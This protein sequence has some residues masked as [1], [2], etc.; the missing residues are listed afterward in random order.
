[1]DYRRV[2]KRI[3]LVWITAGLLFFVMFTSWSVIAYRPSS[4][5]RAATRADALVRVEHHD[6]I[7]TF[8][9]VTNMQARAAFAFVPGALVDARAYAP[10]VRAA[11]AAGYRGYIIELPRRGALGGADAAEV[12]ERLDRVLQQERAAPIVLAGHSRG[13]VVASRI[14][15]RSLPNIAAM[16]LIGT[17]HPRDIDL[18][19]LTIPVVKIVGTRDGLASPSEVRQN[20]AKVPAH[21][22]WVWI[23]GGN[24]SQF[25]W[26][27]FQPG[28]KRPR[29]AAS[30]QRQQMIDVVIETLRA[31]AIETPA[32]TLF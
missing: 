9:P 2:W 8:T 27:G 16:V 24:H 14:A 7:W 21:T 31:V 6:G 22:R 28:D 26:Y 15:A 30:A 29:I 25:G 17:S 20:A 11:A 4:A 10:L 23:D 19:L 12:D 13:A 32:R 5:A 3:R 1:V 18:S